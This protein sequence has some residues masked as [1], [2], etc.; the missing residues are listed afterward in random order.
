MM[1]KMQPAKSQPRSF[2]VDMDKREGFKLSSAFAVL[3]TDR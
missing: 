2:L 3:P 1:R